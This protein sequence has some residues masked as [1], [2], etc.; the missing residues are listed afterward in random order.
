MYVIDQY[1]KPVCMGY[2]QSY[3]IRDDSEVY[4][5]NIL[6]TDASKF[7]MKPAGRPVECVGKPLE[8]DDKVDAEAFCAA[9]N[10]GVAILGL[11]KP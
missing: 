8:F 7:V 4:K 6:D 1:H 5:Q 11:G 2:R 10:L 3:I 9:L